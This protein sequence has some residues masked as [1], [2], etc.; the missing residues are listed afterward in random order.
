MEGFKDSYTLIY[1]TR[2]EEGKMFD[3]KL[4]N[5]TKEECEIIYG[6]ITDEI[7]IWNMILEG[8]F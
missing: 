6:M 4:E 5:Q 2:D 3:I 1:V 7:L 8:M